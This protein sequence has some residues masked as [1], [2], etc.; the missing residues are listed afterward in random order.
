MEEF[1]VGERAILKGNLWHPAEE[2]PNEA[3]SNLLV[4]F[5]DGRFYVVD[6]HRILEKTNWNFNAK[7][8]LY[9]N[10]VDAH[11]YLYIDDLPKTTKKEINLRG[12]FN[13]PFGTLYKTRDGRKAVLVNTSDVINHHSELY[14]QEGGIEDFGN[15]MYAPNGKCLD[16]NSSLDIIGLLN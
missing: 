1:K 9:I 11:S 12:I 8:D 6:T 10:I 2:V 7:W 16:G 15:H 14:V 3:K 5:K 13:K 4:Q